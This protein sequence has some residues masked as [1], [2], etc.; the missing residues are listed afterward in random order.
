MHAWLALVGALLAV[1]P[2]DV[3]RP[4]GMPTEERPVV[5]HPYLYT[6]LETALVLAGGTVWYF[7]NGVD[8]RWGRATDWPAWKRKLMADDVTFDPDRF[9]TNAIGHPM[10]GV[11]YYQIARGNGLGPGEAFVATFLASMFW[12]YL[13][14]IPEYPS[15]NDMIL[16]PGGGAVIGEASY[17]LGRYLAN[18]GTGIGNCVGALLFSPI[19]SLNDRPICRSNPGQLLPRAH[20]GLALGINRAVFDGNVVRDELAV[21][22]GSDI[23]TQRAYQRAGRGSVIVTPGQWTALYGDARFG[24]GRV[25]GVWF[26]AHAVWGGRYDRHYRVEGDETDVPLG[27]T[28]PRGWGTMLGL[29][30]S[31]DYRLRDLPRVRDRVASFGL[32][33]PMFE[34]SS[35]SSVLVRAS[36]TAQYAFAIVDSMAY[37]VESI[38]LVADVI[39]SPLRA[40]GYYYAHGLVSAATLSV[41]LGP[42]GF[43]GD[44]RGG[45]YW[46]IDVGDP[47]QASIQREVELQD[48]RLYLTG[49][50]W[51][52][53][54][55]GALRFGLAVEHVRRAS[56]MLDMSRVGTELNI[57][58]TTAI[59]F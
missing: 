18:S 23:V 1:S 16:T 9:N 32:G 48:R 55:V 51:S 25:D 37:R 49:A 39:K 46:S 36:L 44:A 5:R 30:S 42:V 17:Q 7:R 34:F 26:H 10:G 3:V 57:L 35:R 8:E 56:Y 47:E 4:I 40:S 29:A 53:P 43:S 59:G 45:V 2:D 24:P 20:L 58:A 31:F 21:A 27:P 28:R 14:E 12:E 15:V 19:A 52:R 11:A 13:V 41:D 54:V 50:M 6:A 33:G 38:Q 22:L